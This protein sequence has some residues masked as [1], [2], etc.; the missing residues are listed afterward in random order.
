M[1][2][3][4]AHPIARALATLALLVVALGLPQLLVL[5]EPAVGDVHLTFVASP[6]DC[7]VESAAE[8]VPPAEGPAIGADERH[9]D[10]V[11]LGIELDS[12]R[13]FVL[14]TALT[15]QP[16]TGDFVRQAPP[17][18]AEEGAAARPPSTGPPRP[19]RR[20]EQLVC[21]ILRQ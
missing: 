21:T 17:P 11:P 20:S 9:C 10:H 12:A 4:V 18:A 8:H 2:Q 1:S 19:E 13:R 5:C 16:P 6:D 7:C 15:D 3:P 14:P